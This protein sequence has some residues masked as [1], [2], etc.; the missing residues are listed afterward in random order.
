[1]GRCVINA[2]GMGG[3]EMLSIMEAL[4]LQL[5]FFDQEEDV[6]WNVLQRLKPRCLLEFELRPLAG[7]NVLEL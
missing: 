3:K 2:F 5:F 6:H 4:C 7:T 1:M